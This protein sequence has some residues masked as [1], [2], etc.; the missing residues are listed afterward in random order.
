VDASKQ[1]KKKAQR[2]KQMPVEPERPDEGETIVVLQNAEKL[3]RLLT[4]THPSSL[5]L[6]PAIYFYS[7]SGRH[8]PTA[9]LA[10][11]DL[12]RH[13]AEADK[14]LAFTSVRAVYEDFL[15]D[16]KM[17]VNQLTTQ[18]GSM[19]KGYK[20]LRDYFAFV[21]DQF[22]AGMTPGEVSALLKDHDK[23]QRLVKERPVQSKQPKEFSQSLKQWA[24]LK[25]AIERSIPCR[26]CNARID[27]KAMQLDHV[28]DKK[29]GGYASG[30]NAAWSHPFCNST[31]KDHVRRKDG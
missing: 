6:H 13:L 1:S 16:H 7:A 27:Y 24:F 29:E 26:W 9:V 23:Y 18:H 20:Q 12:I 3:A 30:D 19:A 22:I 11:A 15:R 2:V 25:E 4:G 21:L 5:G 10:V 14:L 8:Q 17:F 31:Y 28:R